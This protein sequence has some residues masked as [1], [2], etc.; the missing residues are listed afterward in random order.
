MLGFNGSGWNKE[1]SQLDLEADY[2]EQKLAYFFWKGQ[3]LQTSQ[4]VRA[5]P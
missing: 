5:L 4:A 2:L 1:L 3:I